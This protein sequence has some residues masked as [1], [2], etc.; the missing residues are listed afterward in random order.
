M[1]GPG[2]EHILSA[3]RGSGGPVPLIRTGGE[4]KEWI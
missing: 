1:R 4:R 3:G 2:Q